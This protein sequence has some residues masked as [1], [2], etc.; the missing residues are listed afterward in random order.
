MVL[1]YNKIQG[2]K[3]KDITL[4]YAKAALYCHTA[5]KVFAKCE[6]QFF[7]IA[8]HTASV[9]GRRPIAG[10]QIKNK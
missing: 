10:I 7:K 6:N 9:G 2:K 8:H 5:I 4:S 3:K 1:I